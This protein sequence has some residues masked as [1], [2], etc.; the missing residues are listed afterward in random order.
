VIN[1]GKNLTTMLRTIEL[2]EEPS[3]LISRVKYERRADLSSILRLKIASHALFFNRRGTITLLSV[4]HG[5]S[6]TFIYQLRDRLAAQVEPL[7]GVANSLSCSTL[8]YWHCVSQLLRLRLQ[9]QS[10]LESI[11]ILMKELGFAYHSVGFISE[12]LKKI[13]DLL[14]NQIDWQGDVVC[15]SDELF[16][17]GHQPIL[18]TSEVSSSAILRIDILSSLTKE[19]WEQHWL[20]LSAAGIRIEKLLTDEGTVL[21]SARQSVLKEVDWQPDS[22][23][24]V[25]HRLGLIGVRL[26]KQVE[27][28]QAAVVSRENRYFTTQTAPMAEKVYGQ[29]LKA[30]QEAADITALSQNF[31]FFYACILQQFTL[32]SS[33][34][35][36]LRTRPYA[37]GEVETALEY[38]YTLPIKG[39]KDAVDDIARILPQL[40]NFL[41]T[42]QEALKELS[43]T[44][45]PAALPF[46]LRAWQRQKNAYKIKKQYQK[47]KKLLNKVE[48][49]VQLLEE[50]YQFKEKQMFTDLKNIIFR[51]LDR[52][53]AQSSAVVENVN[54][55]FRPFLNQSRG[56]ISQ[57]TLNLLMFY[58]NHRPFKRGKKKGMAPIEILSGVKLN[59]SWLDLMLS[60]VQK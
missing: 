7:F 38:L 49:D 56:Q 42:A 31:N 6:R 2:T 16:Y 4:R 24:A 59:K 57:Q 26:S 48:Q 41:D 34:D 55:F 15:A 52:I 1:I 25:S 8:V 39:L 12:T 60:K 46:W 21:Q 32:F 13:G 43:N 11:S 9:G 58:Y 17:S 36:A 45:D 35:A 27:K 47:Q 44:I 28:A 14:G 50:F 53:C 18:I 54:S 29:Y 23:H 22:F 3:S 5:V 10:T 19:A 40:F 20:G 51:A 30:R 33:Q 37:E